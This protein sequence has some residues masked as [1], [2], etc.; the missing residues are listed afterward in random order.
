M[1]VN[2]APAAP[3]ATPTPVAPASAAFSPTPAKPHN[4]APDL[5]GD[6]QDIDDLL[7]GE[8]TIAPAIIEPVSIKPEESSDA[9]ELSDA[10]ITPAHAAEP[11]FGL[12]DAPKQDTGALSRSA[13][14]GIDL[15][16]TDAI[17]LPPALKPAATPAALVPARRSPGEARGATAKVAA[18]NAGPK[19]VNLVPVLEEEFRYAISHGKS[20]VF[21]RWVALQSRNRIVNAV[22]VEKELDGVLAG[23]YAAPRKAG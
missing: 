11:E 10:L 3:A 22:N 7:G 2:T 20:K 13:S 19:V 9:L 6:I 8:E 16:K 4:I 1:L 17:P 23:L 15:E 12:Q 14:D 5:S 21:E 18:G